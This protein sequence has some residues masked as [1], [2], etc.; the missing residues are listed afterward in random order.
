MLFKVW[1]RRDGDEF[2]LNNIKV[3]HIDIGSLCCNKGWVM[4]KLKMECYKC[5]WVFLRYGRAD[6]GPVTVS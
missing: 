5:G 4:D 2:S 6:K 1:Y 3:A